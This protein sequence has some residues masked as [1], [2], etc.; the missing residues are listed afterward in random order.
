M[1]NSVYTATPVGVVNSLPDSV[2]FATFALIN[3]T[4]ADGKDI[5][6]STHKAIVTSWTFNEN[7]NVQFTHTMGNDI[8]LNV[9][10]NRMGVCTIRGLTFNAIGS[11]Q[12]RNC[13]SKSHGVEDIIQWYRDN[14]VSSSQ[15]KIKV[16]IGGDETIE[17]F[18]IGA[19]YQANDP[20]NWTVEYQL[21][22][23][24]IPK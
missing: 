12:G 19:S 21:Q 2:R 18:L 15:D 20:V 16:S 3:V 22:I 10:G 9:F 6:F 13:A 7:V 8:Y 4:G 23:A 17:G 1:P 5:K 24:A 11:G 14:R